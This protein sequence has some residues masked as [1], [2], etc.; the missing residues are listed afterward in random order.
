M[1][2]RTV[3]LCLY[4]QIKQPPTQWK[5]KWNVD[6]ALTTLILCPLVSTAGVQSTTSAF[7][8]ESRRNLR[9]SLR[10]DKDCSFHIQ[11]KYVMTERFK[12]TYID[13]QQVTSFPHRVFFK[14]VFITSFPQDSSLLFH[15]TNNRHSIQLPVQCKPL[16]SQLLKS[17]WFHFKVKTQNWSQYYIYWMSILL[18]FLKW[19]NKCGTGL[20]VCLFTF[21]T[22]LD[23]FIDFLKSN[24]NNMWHL[25]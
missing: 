20:F 24:C 12:E 23:I 19:R 11:G 18:Q 9:I 3:P 2:P 21:L 15:S 1:F 7:E 4:L 25:L 13:R 8:D 6:L 17:L 14:Y 16:I 10:F 5:Q 22:F